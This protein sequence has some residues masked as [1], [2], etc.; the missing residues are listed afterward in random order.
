[1]NHIEGR[2][3]VLRD[4]LLLSVATLMIAL[5]V[6]E[7]MIPCHIVTGSV[8]GLAVLFGELVLVSDSMVVLLLNLSCL[9]IGIRFLGKRFGMHC[10][11]I[12]ILLPAMMAVLPESEGFLSRYGIVNI[13]LFLSL[14]TIGQTIML[15]LD[16]TSGGLDTIAEVLARRTGSSTGMMIALLGLAVSALTV[17]VYGIESAILG[18]L[19]TLINCIMINGLKYLKD[20][21]LHGKVLRA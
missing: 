17:G 14:L 18:T 9:L 5:A 19:V 13:L 3:E 12:S 16:T 7:Y 4:Y 2:K 1:M 8:S 21:A 10:I 20:L 15:S 11:Y 6:K